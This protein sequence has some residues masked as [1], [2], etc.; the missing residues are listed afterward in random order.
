MSASK[1]DRKGVLEGGI[2]IRN[3]GHDTGG[4]LGGI[5]KKGI[6]IEILHHFISFVLFQISLRV[7]CSEVH[8]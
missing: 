7:V 1:E 3:K 4:Q 5:K 8:M 6:E 2:T